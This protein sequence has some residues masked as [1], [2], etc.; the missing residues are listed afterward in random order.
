MPPKKLDIWNYFH[1]G[2]TQNTAHKRAYCL[3]CL[4]QHRPADIIDVDMDSEGQAPQMA[5]TDWIDA[6]EARAVK[7]S[8]NKRSRDESADAD[9]TADSAKPSKKHASFLAVEK[10]MKQPQL[11]VFKGIDMPFNDAQTDMVKAQ[12]LRATVSANLPFLWTTDAEVI[13]LFLMFRSRA[14]DVMPSDDVLSGRLLD[15]SAAQVDSDVKAE[16]AGKSDGWKDKNSVTGVTASAEG[17]THLV[18]L[19]HTRGKKKD[20]ASMCDAFCGHIDKIEGDTGGIVVAYITDNDG[21]S[22]RGRKDLV[23]IRPYIFGIQCCSHQG[24]L[25][26][27]DYFK[28]N[29]AANAT[30]E[31]TAG[32]IGWINRHEAVRDIFDETQQQLASRPQGESKKAALMYLSANLTRWTTH[33]ISWNRQ[34]ELK[35]SLRN[36]AINRRQDITSAQVGAE[37]N[38]KKV[39][40]M[41][42]EADKYCELF[43]D[44]QYWKRLQT[45]ADDV[46]PITFITNINQGDTTRADQVIMGL[47]GVYLHFSRH[48]N[49]SVAAGMAKR[50][51]KRW[52]DFDQPFFVIALVLNPYEK[53]SRFGDE[54]G[55]QIFAIHSVF[56][57]LYRRVRS[58][59]IPAA[60]SQTER[61]AL[62]L[63]KA[64]K[65]TAVSSA[66]LQYLGDENSQHF[67]YFYDQRDEFQKLHGDNPVLVWKQFLAVPE[68]RELADFAIL[69]LG[70]VVNSGG[71]ERVFSDLKIKR[72]RLRNRLTFAK[73]EKMSKVGASI[74]AEHLAEGLRKV[75]EPR[76]NHDASRVADLIA[77]PKYADLLEQNE[78]ADSDSE[79]TSGKKAAW[80]K[81]YT[82]WVVSAR[83]EEMAAEENGEAYEPTVPAPAGRIIGSILTNNLLVLGI[84]FLSAGVKFSEFGYSS[85]TAQMTVQL[86]S[87]VAFPIVIIVTFV[88]F[89]SVPPKAPKA[90]D[91]GIVVFRLSHGAIASHAIR[92]PWLFSSGSVS[93]SPHFFL[94]KRDLSYTMS[95]IFQFQVIYVDA[96]ELLPESEQSQEDILEPERSLPTIPA[97]VL[98]PVAAVFGAVLLL[99]LGPDA[100]PGHDLLEAL[101]YGQSFNNGIECAFNLVIRPFR[102]CIVVVNLSLTQGRNSWPTGLLFICLYIIIGTTFF[103]YLD[104]FAVLCLR[105]KATTVQQRRKD[106]E[107]TGWK[108]EATREKAIIWTDDKG[109][110]NRAYA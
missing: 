19:I 24:Q 5:S 43:D 8:N 102:Q 12:F 11:K 91:L 60:V 92:F 10:K 25:I 85:L 100:N 93:N 21:G 97:I 52:A 14:T 80:R 9:N 101:K 34:L 64:Q 70:I 96:E 29:P 54:A 50:L 104:R 55:V 49:P 46:E 95:L 66:F 30:A 76:K 3:G 20:G 45:I 99:K 82:A 23:I 26:L 27:L 31:E 73:T 86:L 35:T 18:D 6:A 2:G 53:L 77:V 108:W 69:I 42:K 44:P 81:V 15:E 89:L 75:R 13:K 4:E 106:H 74:R 67:S 109:L 105:G 47:A 59:P 28:E 72:T 98:F 48:S 79:D 78:D 7:A 56:M 58:R 63:Q 33:T 22:Q 39:A 65:E 36:A 94:A 84:A 107:Q 51:E 62:L 61:E 38:K 37:K 16:L 110:K 17:K 90:A 68:V 1:E 57:D 103:F 40:A 71:T 41:K 87:F 83:E 88:L 32:A